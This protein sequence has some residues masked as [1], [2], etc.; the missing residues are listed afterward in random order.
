MKYIFITCFPVNLK[1]A[2]YR[3]YYITILAVSCTHILTTFLLHHFSGKRYCI[4]S[5]RILYH[6]NVIYLTSSVST[7]LQV[8]CERPVRQCKTQ[9]D[10]PCDATATNID[11]TITNHATDMHPLNSSVTKHLRHVTE[12]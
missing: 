3:S 10:A 12:M 7:R 5:Y 1:Y 4:V 6:D 11:D 9:D 2:M 8:N